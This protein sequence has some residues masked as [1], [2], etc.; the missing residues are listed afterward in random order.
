[1]FVASLHIMCVCVRAVCSGWIGG[2][3]CNTT[4]DEQVGCVT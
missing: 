4:L 1:M 3:S 2:E